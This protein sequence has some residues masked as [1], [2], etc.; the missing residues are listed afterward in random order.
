MCI[1]NDLGA[2]LMSN[3]R[4]TGVPMRALLDAAGPKAGVVE[5]RLHGADGYVDTFAYQKALDPTTLLVY[6]MNGA[7]LPER[8]GYPVRAIGA[9]IGHGG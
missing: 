1:S 9:P 6:A 7:P 3:A 5:V 4:W 2:G 8:H